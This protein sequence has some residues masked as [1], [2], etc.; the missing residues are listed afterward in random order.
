MHSKDPT[1]SINNANGK[2]T[3]RDPL[4]PGVSFHP[5]P[6]S[7]P[8]LELIKQNVPYPQKFTKFN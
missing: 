3:N 1:H 8:P 6:V 2:M 7:K 4:I 5:G